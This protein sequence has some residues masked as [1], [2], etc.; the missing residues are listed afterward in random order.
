MLAAPTMQ[1][2]LATETRFGNVRAPE[3]LSM[4]RLFAQVA[5]DRNGAYG[6]LS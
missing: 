3:M 2:S 1:R 5:L 4:R 6:F